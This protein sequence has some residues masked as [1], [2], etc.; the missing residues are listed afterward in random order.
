MRESL[1][2]HYHW[3]DSSKHKTLPGHL[4]QDTKAKSQV[5]VSEPGHLLFRVGVSQ[6]LAPGLGGNRARRAGQVS[7]G[8]AF[9]KSRSCLWARTQAVPSAG[10]LF[11]PSYSHST[12]ISRRGSE[13]PP[14]EHPASLRGFAGMGG[15][16][17]ASGPHQNISLSSIRLRFPT[18]RGCF[19]SLSFQRH[20]RHFLNSPW[21]S[22]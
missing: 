9:N 16:S 12:Q 4:P 20:G 5:S 3:L 8:Q 19:S 10:T 1:G 6:G 13:A 15:F 14:S 18:G 21:T 11:P 17:R 7:W 2:Q 22:L